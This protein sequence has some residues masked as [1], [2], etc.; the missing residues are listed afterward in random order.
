MPAAAIHVLRNIAWL[1]LLVQYMPQLAPQVPKNAP[2]AGSIWHES[3]EFV[4]DYDY[5][6]NRAQWLCSLCSTESAGGPLF[7]VILCQIET[8]AWDTIQRYQ[9]KKG[10]VP[11]KRRIKPECMCRMHDTTKSS[12][13]LKPSYRDSFEHPQSSDNDFYDYPFVTF[14]GVMKGP[15]LK[16]Q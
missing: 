7:L 4:F 12:L 15:H 14:N 11:A 13:R 3:D 5:A 1:I 10:Q 8:W 9:K 16:K 6:N 2:E